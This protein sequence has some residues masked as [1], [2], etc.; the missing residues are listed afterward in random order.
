M[1]WSQLKKQ[2]YGLMRSEFRDRVGIHFTRYRQSHDE[3]YGRGWINLDGEQLLDASDFRHLFAENDEDTIAEA[4]AAFPDRVAWTDHTGTVTS[5]SIPHLLGTRGVYSR[6]G[7]FGLLYDYIHAPVEK[8][9]VSSYPLI[10]ALALLDRRVGRRSLGR[11]EIAE[12]EHPLVQR[13][14]ALRLSASRA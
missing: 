6:R 9:L 7:F 14:Y 8:S 3:D 12:T 5:G 1:N 4:Q 2:L 13:F 10:R 11:L